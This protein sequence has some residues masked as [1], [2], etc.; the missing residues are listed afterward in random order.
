MSV[1]EKIVKVRW[2]EKTAEG[3]REVQSVG[4]VEFDGR[5]DGG[6]CVAREL[7]PS[8]P[9]GYDHP[10]NLRFNSYHCIGKDEIIEIVE[11]EEKRGGK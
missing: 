10:P 3:K 9:A 5:P 2:M 8:E 7:R 6:I 11:L 4:F 1:A